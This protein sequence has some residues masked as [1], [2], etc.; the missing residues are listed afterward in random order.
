MNDK[1]KFQD[2]FVTSPSLPNLDELKENLDRIWASKIITNNGPYVRSLESDLERYLG[3][4]RI[5][6]FCNGTITLLA[7]IGS[8]NMRGEIITT[9]FTFAATAASIVWAGC[10]PVFVDIDLETANIC[11]N[12]IEKSI[13]KKTVAIMAVHC[14]GNVCEVEEIER[15]AS[16]HNLKVIY[17]AAHAFGVKYKNRSILEYGDISSLSFHATK[18][19]NTIE[20]GAL[21]VNSENI[22][23]KVRNIR[24][25]GIINENEITETGLNGKMNEVL[26]AYGIL[27]L[28]KV[29]QEIEKRRQIAHLY[30]ELLSVVPGLRFP[31]FNLH[32]TQNYSYFPVIFDQSMKVSR[33]EVYENLKDCG[34][35][36]RKYFSPL[37][38]DTKAFRK[39]VRKENRD[40]VNAKQI[41]KNVLCLP[42]Y[43]DMPVEVVDRVSSAFR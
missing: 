22:H 13:T 36:S 17:D 8:L 38:S 42:I 12:L 5:S 7:A 39:Y 28:K 16:M 32:Q 11:P 15:I 6:L 19:F 43:G 18:V 21:A 40:L 26:A 1:K 29:D 34:I 33:D 31:K 10:R 23:A 20:G 14:Y 2:I 30:S 35:F 4:S 9:P 24:N 25:F 41:A 37:L 3:V 27:N